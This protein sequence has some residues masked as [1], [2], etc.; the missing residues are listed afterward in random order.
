MLAWSAVLFSYLRWRAVSTESAVVAGVVGNVVVALAWFGPPLMEARVNN[1]AL[2]AWHA[3]RP[4]RVRAE[5]ARVPLRHATPGG[6]AE[7]FANPAE[8]GVAAGSFDAQFRHVA[9]RPTA[10]R[11]DD[12]VLVDHALTASPRSLLA[13]PAAAGKITDSS[14]NSR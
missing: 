6:M 14:L 2:S 9:Q 10:A 7:D 13:R 11:A 5:P 8:E 12:H 1:G 3:P 4:G